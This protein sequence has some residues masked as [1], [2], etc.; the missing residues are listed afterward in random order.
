MTLVDLL[1]E[2]HRFT[3]ESLDNY[4]LV[5]AN[6][7][8]YPPIRFK[9][10]Y[11]GPRNVND[12]RDRA[13][14]VL[15]QVLEGE[16]ERNSSTVSARIIVGIYDEDLEQGWLNTLNVIEHLRQDLL[17]SPPLGGKYQR[18]DPIKWSINDQ[19]AEPT[20]I[21]W[22]D[23]KFYIGAPRNYYDMEEAYSGL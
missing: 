2:L 18:E 16:D 21:G 17:V 13:P 22:L 9:K 4:V 11:F 12:R 7:V 8:A 5:D 23:I 6:N 14:Y 15:A 10:G 20:W 3:K 1:E 19:Q